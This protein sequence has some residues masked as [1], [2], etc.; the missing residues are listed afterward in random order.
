MYLLEGEALKDMKDPPTAPKQPTGECPVI[1]PFSKET[2]N[3]NAELSG[4]DL[5]EVLKEIVYWQQPYISGKVFLAIALFYYATLEGG[6][7][8]VNLLVYA[9][10]LR[11]ISVAGKLCQ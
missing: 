6:Y 1:T 2:P 11:L 8:P 5:R 7:D 4:D 9:L 3:G 10:T